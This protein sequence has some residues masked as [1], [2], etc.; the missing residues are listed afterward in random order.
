MRAGAAM[1]ALLAMAGLLAACSPQEPARP[2]PKPDNLTAHATDRNGQLTRGRVSTKSGEILIL[3]P[4]GTVTQLALDS[5]A[6]RNAFDLTESDL[7]AL[8][9]NLSL[10]LSGLPPA[11]GPAAPGRMTAQQRALEAFAARSRPL[12]PAVPQGID[13]QYFIDARV[14]RLDDGKGADGLVM[15]AADL[16][17]GV[18][19]E[20]AFAYA[21]C[22]LAGWAEA[23]RIG[24][25]RHVRSLSH[26][27]RGKTRIDAV[28]T[29]S[30]G[31][32]PMGL[33][34][35]EPKETLAACEQAGVPL[36]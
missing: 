31:V 34:V 17:A 11:V 26:R 27:K 36:A 5:P 14:T 7:A 6:G 15:V 9:V 29:L 28:F 32:R 12:L 30:Q 21:T 20:T 1:A 33:R 24:Y 13:R 8:G 16:A 25:A 18:D 35:M 10:D 4:D 22:A 3:E 23:N 2:M 19:A